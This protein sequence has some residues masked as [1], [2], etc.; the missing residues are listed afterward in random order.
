MQRPVVTLGPAHNFLRAWL[1]DTGHVSFQNEANKSNLQ[2]VYEIN[3]LLNDSFLQIWGADF[4]I[5][6]SKSPQF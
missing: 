5:Q 3:G 6:K 2:T 1:F 4:R